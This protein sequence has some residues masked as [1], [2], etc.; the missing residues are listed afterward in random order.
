VGGWSVSD[1]GHVVGNFSF[2]P[3][4]ASVLLRLGLRKSLIC[5]P[6]A[7]TEEDLV[8]GIVRVTLF[9]TRQRSSA[10]MRQSTVSRCSA[11]SE[12]G[13]GHLGPFYTS[14][15]NAAFVTQH[16]TRGNADRT[17]K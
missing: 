7:G 6:S 2:K 12:E 13:G 3:K 14:V 4:S 17:F 1:G 16:K 10:R 15:E 11:H 8:A 5:E 9:R